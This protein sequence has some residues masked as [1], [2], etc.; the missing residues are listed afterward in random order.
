M[1]RIISLVINAE[2]ESLTSTKIKGFRAGLSKTKGWFIKIF[3][4]QV[5]QRNRG[6]SIANHERMIDR[7]CDRYTENI[8]MRESGEII[9]SRDELLSEHTGHGSDKKNNRIKE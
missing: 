4:G 7:D 2:T 6:N 1:H 9:H 3:S 5:V 8:T